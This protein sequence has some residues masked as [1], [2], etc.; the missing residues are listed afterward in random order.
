METTIN[1]AWKA[2][3][4]RTNPDIYFSIKAIENK[5]FNDLAIK[6]IGTIAMGQMRNYEIIHSE[7]GLLMAHY[8]KNE[9]QIYI[10]VKGESLQ[11][12]K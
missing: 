10:F 8:S 5:N 7:D 9:N 2:K 3:T 1:R 6:T 11:F 12:R 4:R